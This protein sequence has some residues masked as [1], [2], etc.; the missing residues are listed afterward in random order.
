MVYNINMENTITSTKNPI[1][2]GIKKLQNSKERIKSGRFVVEGE[3]CVSEAL[4]IDGLCEKLL[5]LE[6]EKDRY[7]EIISGFAGEII[8]ISSAVLENIS[9]VK[10][11]QS[12]IAV[13]I[14]E[15][16][17]LSKSEGLIIILDGVSDP[18]N[19]GAIIRTADAVDAGEI[20]LLNNCVDFLSPKVIRAS[21]GSVFHLQ[22]VKREIKDLRE[23]KK[24]G[25]R[26][27]GADIRGKTDFDIAFE[28]ICL[29]IGSEAHGISDEVSDLLDEKIRIPI[30]GKAESLNAAVAASVLMY[31]L[32]G[33]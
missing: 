9:T 30:Y 32:K 12:I 29:V 21:M 10:T 19:L 27:F 17:I 26:I 22:I 20:L 28:K 23:Y 8:Y 25:Y 13:C 33:L 5:V 4:D 14:A 6:S 3:K 18:G 31:K 16:L 1:I 7:G 24:N 2:K 11:P 15:K